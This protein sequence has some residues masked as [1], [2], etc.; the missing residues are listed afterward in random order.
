MYCC[1]HAYI[2][3]YTHT[4]THTHTNTHTHRHR[5]NVEVRIRTHSHKNSTLNLAQT[6][7]LG[8]GTVVEECFSIETEAKYRLPHIKWAGVA[9]RVPYRVHLDSGS[10][11]IVHRD[12]HFLIRDLALQA[13]GPRQA[14][15]GTRCLQR[16][17]TRQRGD[18]TWEAVD[19]NTR[20]VRNV[21]APTEE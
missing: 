15:D 20:K 19:H 21:S 10:T 3:T 18:G 17:E 12:E 14:A 1:I 7:M 5:H 8:P 13:L 9:T 11:I 2:H 4:H 6:R 16:I